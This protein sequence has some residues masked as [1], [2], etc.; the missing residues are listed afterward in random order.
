VTAGVL[1]PVPV[2]LPAA[3][4]DDGRCRRSRGNVHDRLAAKISDPIRID[5]LT[6]IGCL[7]QVGRLGQADSPISVGGL[8]R[9]CG[10]AQV[11]GLADVGGL[12]RV[13]GE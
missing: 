9:A 5:G 7:A 2:A 4:D 11:G 8:A 12:E 1:A 6:Q 10:L 3:Q 13:G